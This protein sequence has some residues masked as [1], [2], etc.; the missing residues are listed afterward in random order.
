MIQFLN[1]Y[2]NNVYIKLPQ[3]RKDHAEFR[4]F[5]KAV[6]IHAFNKHIFYVL[7]TVLS[8]GNI[9]ANKPSKSLVSVHNLS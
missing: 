9:K 3:S 5:R 1:C 7:G 6:I 4:L 8:A 2:K